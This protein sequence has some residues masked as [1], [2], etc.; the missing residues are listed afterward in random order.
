MTEAPALEVDRVLLGFTRAL[1]AA[2]VA[3]TPDRTQT[4]LAAAAALGAG[5]PRAVARAGRAT[6]CGSLEDLDR[7]DQVFAAW[8]G[9]DLP[10]TRP[11]TA[12][13]VTSSPALDLAADAGADAEQEG[14]DDPLRAAA[15]ATEVLRHRDVG[16]LDARERA[17]LAAL[18]STLHPRAPRRRAHRRT[19]WRRGEV[20]ARATLRRMLAAH[21]EPA[22]LAGLP[23]SLV[24]PEFAAVVG[25]LQLAAEQ[26]RHVP[27]RARP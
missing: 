18:F 4:Y 2:G 19:A 3:V 13:P 27:G 17:A 8:F 5:D 12:P 10:R 6:L 1:T 23:E 26:R 22:R 21:G 9:E 24:R 11:A 15:S 25:L 16:E 7:H 20:D 14:D